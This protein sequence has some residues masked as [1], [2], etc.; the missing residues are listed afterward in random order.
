MLYMDTLAKGH[1]ETK[2]YVASDWKP[3]EL[4]IVAKGS[5]TGR[6]AYT[7]LAFR[8]NRTEAL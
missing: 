5:Y 8:L 7:A 1:Q 6:K 3:L 2:L 4:I